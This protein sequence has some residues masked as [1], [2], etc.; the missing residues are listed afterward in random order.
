MQ[1]VLS[2]RRCFDVYKPIF[3]NASPHEQAEADATARKAR[4]LA[5][6]QRTEIESSVERNPI[7]AGVF[8]IL[9][10][11]PANINTDE[12]ERMEKERSSAMPSFSIPRTG[13]FN[14]IAPPTGTPWDSIN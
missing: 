13:A 9:G 11:W 10:E 2:R 7:S 3:R 6:Q 4:E 1:P 5:N 12:Q 8:R 14:G